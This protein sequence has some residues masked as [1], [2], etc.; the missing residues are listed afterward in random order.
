MS[1][2]L[3]GLTPTQINLL[4]RVLFG[5]YIEQDKIYREENG[6]LPRVP[7]PTPL[8]RYFVKE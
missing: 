2:L 1:P 6:L 8:P 5:A 3:Q 7:P 4:L